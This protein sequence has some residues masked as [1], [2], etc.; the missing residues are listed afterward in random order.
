MQILSR[1]PSLGILLSRIEDMLDGSWMLRAARCV[2]TH[3]TLFVAVLVMGRAFLDGLGYQHPDDPILLSDAGQHLLKGEISAVYL[4]ERVQV[5]PLGLVIYGVAGVLQEV[6]LDLLMGLTLVAG[7][8]FAAGLWYCV[9]AVTPQGPSW[10]WRAPLA[11]VVAVIGGLSWTASTSGHP[12]EGFVALLWIYAAFAAQRDKPITAGVA[13]GLASSVKLFAILGLPLLLLLPDAR[14]VLKGAGGIV[15]VAASLW[16]PVILAGPFNML[17]FS[18]QIKPHSPLAFLFDAGSGFGWEL[19]V[20]QAVVVCGLGGLASLRL[21]GD[22]FAHL[23]VPLVLMGLRLVTDPL[24]Y[25]YY[26][27]GPGTI[28]LIAWVLLS[29]GDRKVWWLGLPLIYY[30]ALVPFFLWGGHL[31]GAW[32]LLI[33]AAFL[34]PIFFWRSSAPATADLILERSSQT[35]Q[36]SA[37]RSRSRESDISE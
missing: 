1:S 9:K 32:I 24:D 34:S 30:L 4:D 2:K 12:T 3:P 17:D 15:L 37:L 7:I 25:H 23:K 22:P 16:L 28:G 36:V 11:V 18:W 10:R 13:L 14:R 35:D 33:A 19:R 8:S 21:R 6:G 26:L 27:L 31:L 29:R 5:G 20:L